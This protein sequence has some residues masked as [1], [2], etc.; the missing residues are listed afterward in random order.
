M[1][2]LAVVW[3]FLDLVVFAA[4]GSY[5][6]N[7][8]KNHCMSISLL[9]AAPNPHHSSSCLCESITLNK[10][11]YIISSLRASL[12]SPQRD[13]TFLLMS[14]PS[15]LSLIHQN[16][17]QPN[18][19]VV[20]LHCL[21]VWWKSCVIIFLKNTTIYV[22]VC[23]SVFIYESLSLMCKISAHNFNQTSKIVYGFST[24]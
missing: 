11:K 2:R 20:N 14:A 22:S 17:Q 8:G 21:A 23:V 13:Y 9:L 6:Y 3:S 5:L 12:N 4:Q 7:S 19:K 1:N 15:W 10:T 16:T 24:L 18:H